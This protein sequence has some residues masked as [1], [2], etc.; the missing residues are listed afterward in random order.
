MCIPAAIH[1][2]GHGKCG[3]L[4]TPAFRHCIIPFDASPFCSRKR[5]SVKLT[6]SFLIISLQQAYSVLQLN[7]NEMT[8]TKV[9]S[10]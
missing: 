10:I 2:D 9:A 5:L 4:L 6:G 1:R 7:Q 8:A 3:L